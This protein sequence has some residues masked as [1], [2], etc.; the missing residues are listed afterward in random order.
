MLKELIGE[1]II[2]SVKIPTFRSSVLYKSS[3]AG[4]Y[5]LIRMKGKLL[6]IE[7]GFAFVDLEKVKSDN[8]IDDFAIGVCAINLSD[9][10]MIKKG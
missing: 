9:I 2:L 1:K 7:E 4:G 8:L 10:N 5:T 6:S 3:Y